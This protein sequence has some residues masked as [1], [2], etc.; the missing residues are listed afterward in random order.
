MAIKYLTCDKVSIDDILKVLKEGFK[1]HAISIEFTNES[2]EQ[3]VRTNDVK[4]DLSLMAFADEK[5][6]GCWLTGIRDINGIRYG[7]CAALTII[8]SYRGKKFA[9]NLSKRALELQKEAGVKITKLYVLK[10]NTPAYNLYKKLGYRDVRLRYSLYLKLS[11]LEYASQKLNITDKAITVNDF[12]LCMKDQEI[13]WSL[14]NYKRYLNAY[15]ALIGKNENETVGFIGFYPQDELFIAYLGMS[16]GW[17][18]PSVA[19]TLI[20]AAAKYVNATP[21]TKI[22]FFEIDGKSYLYGILKEFGKIKKKYVKV[23]MELEL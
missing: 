16:Y 15:R 11:E 21:D 23:E 5:P 9:Y 8:P 6:I 2:F 12:E 3:I 22:L 13:P 19:S 20:R 1:N 18:T 4:L 10:D 7:Y 17:R 14:G